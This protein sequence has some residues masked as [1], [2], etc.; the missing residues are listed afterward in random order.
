[1]KNNI[2]AVITPNIKSDNPSD[3]LYD[4]KEG[5]VVVSVEITN[6]D[7]TWQRKLVGFSTGM[8]TRTA[9]KSNLNLD[10]LRE[11]ARTN[12]EN[13]YDEE[14]DHYMT[15][16]ESRLFIEKEDWKELGW[17]HTSFELEDAK[18]EY[19]QGKWFINNRD[20]NQLIVLDTETKDRPFLKWVYNYYRG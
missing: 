4:V 13:H 3:Y 16:M 1:M 8:E 19:A 15:D 7:Y 10:L 2:E 11:I 17:N 18:I 9:L 12:W 14:T 6:G 20:L 5:D